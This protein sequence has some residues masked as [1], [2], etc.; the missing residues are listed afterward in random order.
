MKKQKKKNRQKKPP[1]QTEQIRQP[2]TV[3][4]QSKPMWVRILILAIVAVMILGLI[5]GAVL[6]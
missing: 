4:T 2:V 1:Q 3:K 6:S 5:I